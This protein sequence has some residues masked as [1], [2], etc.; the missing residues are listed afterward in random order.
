MKS[1]IIANLLSNN[2][3][4]F[5]PLCDEDCIIIEQQGLLKRCFLCEGKYIRSGKKVTIDL[6][7]EFFNKSIR[8]D[9]VSI[10]Y[11][12]VTEETTKNV[13]LVPYQ[14]VHNKK[15]INLTKGTWELPYNYSETE[16]ITLNA[17]NKLERQQIATHDAQLL[18]LLN[19][20]KQNQ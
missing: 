3:Q 18:D 5:I 17:V 11:L 8:W 16:R 6:Q 10:D 14:D 1:N 19:A 20:Q 13:W 4:V 15:Y 9:F 7:R 12:I 2:Y